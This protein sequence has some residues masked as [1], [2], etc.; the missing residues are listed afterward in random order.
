MSGGQG[1]VILHVW[2]AH[3]G[4]GNPDLSVL[5]MQQRAQ[6][7]WRVESKF[8][9]GSKTGEKIVGS[10]RCWV[11]KGTYTRL[12]YFRDL[13]GLPCGTATFPH[14]YIQAQDDWV[15]VDPIENNDPSVT[16][17]FSVTR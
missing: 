13:D 8:S 10:A 1:G 3:I 12:E 9:D 2:P 11:P 17:M 16:D 5:P 6:I 4:F 15:D 14:P 7:Q